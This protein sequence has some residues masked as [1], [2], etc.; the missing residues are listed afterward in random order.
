MRNGH[1]LSLQLDMAGYDCSSCFTASLSRHRQ[2]FKAAFT[3]VAALRAPG[4]CD[5][6][7]SGSALFPL[8]YM[9]FCFPVAFL[10]APC[11][12]SNLRSRRKQLDWGSISLCLGPFPTP[13]SLPALSSQGLVLVL[14]KAVSFS[15][16]PAFSAASCE[17][18]GNTDTEWRG[19][20]VV[21]KSRG[22]RKWARGYCYHPA[23]QEKHS[24]CLPRPN[25][26]NRVVLWH[27]RVLSSFAIFL[28]Y[29]PSLATSTPAPSFLLWRLVWR[30]PGRR[31]QP[32]LWLGVNQE[33]S[34]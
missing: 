32:A 12:K 24:A 25:A 7:R 28:H 8:S 9:Y 20:K 21:T 17:L 34:Q 2:P 30:G 22:Q 10:Q 3:S 23:S 31:G 29:T 11:S 27:S 19:E 33:C 16:L 4:G 18:K 15:L 6:L 26:W 5:I 14:I 1:E 13:L